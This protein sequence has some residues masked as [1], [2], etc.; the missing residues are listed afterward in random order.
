[1]G[2]EERGT[3]LF[4]SDVIAKIFSRR[5][6]DRIE[7]RMGRAPLALITAQLPGI[8]DLVGRH[9]EE[10]GFRFVAAAR[11]EIHRFL[12]RLPGCRLLALENLAVD[13][14]LTCL[15]LDESELRRLPDTAMRLQLRLAELLHAG[16]DGDAPR[17]DARV[18]Y[19]WIEKHAPQVFYQAL[20][21]SLCDA[22]RIAAAGIEARDLEWHHRF[23]DLLENPPERG[24]LRVVYQPIC[25]LGTGGSWGGKSISGGH[26][27][28]IS[29]LPGIF[30]PTPRRW[31]RWFRWNSVA[32]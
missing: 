8:A 5:S 4:F 24:G 7:A 28:R 16:A 21:K 15:C 30:W 19:A 22:R 17:M 23:L 9:G 32:W 14:C 12:E 25:H 10:A 20:F 18:G 27:T 6:L 3:G 2:L 31:D 26:R 11:G 1:M 13:E 29:T